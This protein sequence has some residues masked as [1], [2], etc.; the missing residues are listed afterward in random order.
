MHSEEYNSRLKHRGAVVPD[1]LASKSWIPSW[2][3]IAFALGI[4][5]KTV[6]IQRLNI[7]K[8]LSFY[9][10]AEL[11]NCAVHEGLITI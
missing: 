3:S 10:I 9:S 2:K 1:T 7:M 11:T 4:N 6:E 8:E 5:I